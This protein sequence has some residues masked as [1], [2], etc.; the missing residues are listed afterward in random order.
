ML[1]N[2]YKKSLQTLAAVACVGTVAGGVSAWSYNDLPSDFLSSS[3]A[4]LKNSAAL[5]VAGIVSQEMYEGRNNIELKVNKFLW[6]S[7]EITGSTTKYSINS[8]IDMLFSDSEFSASR[9]EEGYLDGTVNRPGYKLG[10][11][12]VDKNNYTL[13]TSWSAEDV[14]LEDIIV[15]DGHISGSIRRP[16][17]LKSTIEIRGFYTPE[18]KVTMTIDNE[19]IYGT[20][21]EGTITPRK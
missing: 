14:E 10:I 2:L 3:D 5:V 7:A 6:P 16:G 4:K 20:T 17:F 11:S 21:L 8:K 13:S 1:K 19:F 15:K 9:T 18:G 12:S